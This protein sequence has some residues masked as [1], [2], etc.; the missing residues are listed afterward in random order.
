MTTAVNTLKTYDNRYSVR[1]INLWTDQ[2]N[3][4][5]MA[6]SPTSLL[7]IIKTNLSSP[8]GGNT[9]KE[10]TTLSN[11]ANEP[12]EVFACV[13]IYNSQDRLV[14]V[15]AKKVPLAAHEVKNVPFDLGL[16]AGSAEDTYRASMFLW[17]NTIKPYFVA[18]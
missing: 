3:V 13:A 10:V 4:A 9:Y 1:D 2:L 14:D 7:S 8:V 11:Y 5:V 18:T 12:I 16:I 6:H 17:S 15:V